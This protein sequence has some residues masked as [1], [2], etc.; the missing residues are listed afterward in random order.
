MRHYIHGA[1]SS[2]D[3]VVEKGSFGMNLEMET[4]MIDMMKTQKISDNKILSDRLLKLAEEMK[5]LNES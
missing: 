2:E 4:K 3:K 1:E 5:N